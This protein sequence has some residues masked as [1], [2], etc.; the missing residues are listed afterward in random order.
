[1]KNNQI[2]AESRT[3]VWLFKISEDSLPT[4]QKV[5]KVKGIL[6]LDRLFFENH[7]HLS[8]ICKTVTLISCDGREGGMMMLVLGR[9]VSWWVW[10]KTDS[11]SDQ[12]TPASI[13]T[14]SYCPPQPGSTPPPPSTYS[15]PPSG[16]LLITN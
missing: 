12:V 3:H 7:V 13:V 15:P 6:N 2:L 14:M 16:S 4:N 11:G 8:F 5:L 1:M 10:T 9:C